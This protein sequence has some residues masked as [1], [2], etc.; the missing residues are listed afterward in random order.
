MK[1]VYCLNSIRYLGGIQRVTV[2]KANALADVPGNEVY[3]VV[4]DNKVGVSVQPL[5]PKV[6]LIDL[7]INHYDGDTE[8]SAFGDLLVSIH[9]RRLHKKRLEEFLLNLRP[10]IVISV[11]TSEKYMLLSMKNRTWKVIREFHFER[12]YRKKYAVT[13]FDRLMASLADF[14]EFHFKIK[15]YDKIV[16]LTHEDR[17][18]NWHN[19]SKTAVITNAISFTCENPSSLDEKF[20]SMVGRLD[21]VKNCE[22]MIR[23]FNMVA[24]RHPDW[25]LRLYGDGSEREKLQRLIADLGL[26]GNVE[27]M[28]FTKDVRAAFSKSS[29]A[30]LSSLCEGFALVIIEA[31]E[32]GVP[33]VSYQCPCGPRDLITEGVDGFLV[34]VNDEE[35]M[36]N[37]ICQLIEDEELRKTMGHAAKEKARNYHID[38][39][40][41]QWMTLFNEVIN[42]K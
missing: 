36:A 2:T 20:V 10:D 24:K 31:M 23:A 41:K 17:E 38:N 32:C 6:H 19:W 7:E 25:T 27:L 40:T 15:K 12:F 11:G 18:D 8:R 22:S 34:P 33:F 3:V 21:P 9:K 5:S 29:I 14:Y 30:C 13:R 1:I 16:L 42:E 26:Q 4:T 39:I 35:T 37:R 28:G